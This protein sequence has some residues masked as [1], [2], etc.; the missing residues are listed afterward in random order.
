MAY[1]HTIACWQLRRWMDSMIIRCSLFVHWNGHK[2]AYAL[3]MICPLSA[4]SDR[5]FCFNG[6]YNM[7][8]SV[9][10][11]NVRSSRSICAVCTW[12][13][14]RIAEKCRLSFDSLFNRRFFFAVHSPPDLYKFW[15]VFISAP[16][17]WWKPRQPSSA[18]ISVAWSNVR[19]PEN[20][21]NNSTM[22]S[23]TICD[24]C[25]CVCV[26]YS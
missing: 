12:E 23:F 16:C 20:H 8:A 5:G 22:R 3:A 2:H 7:H 25:V 13:P 10:C 15:P 21:S 6:N 9:R 26:V 14:E 1:K 4:W 17:T 24:V 11:G 18:W 19:S